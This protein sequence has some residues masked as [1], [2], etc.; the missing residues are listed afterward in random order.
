MEF[1][2]VSRDLAKRI[3]RRARSLDRRTH[4]KG[5]HGGIV[6]P[7][8]LAVL[9]ALVFR[10]LDYRTG[11]LA[12]SHSDLAK[13]ASVSGIRQLLSIKQCMILVPV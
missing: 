9:E 7:P 4:T 2:P 3:F 13:A 10:H 1:R 11:N 12:P 5:K 6:G 8:A